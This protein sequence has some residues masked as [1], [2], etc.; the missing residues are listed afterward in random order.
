MFKSLPVDMLNKYP[1]AYLQ[2]VALVI[3][4]GPPDAAME[5]IQRLEQLRVYYEQSPD[6]PE[7][8][9]NRILA[10]IEV[11]EVFASFNDMHKMIAHTK[12]A[13]ELLDGATCYMVRR[14]DEFTFGVPSFTSTTR[15]GKLKENRRGGSERLSFVPQSP[16]LRHRMQYLILASSP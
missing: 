2:Y 4:N 7:R 3:V 1:V 9:R 11:V 8:E 5:G 15:S 14:I 16:T 6:I 13:M 10:E 12:R